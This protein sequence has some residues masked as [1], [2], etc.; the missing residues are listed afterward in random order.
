[1]HSHHKLILVLVAAGVVGYAVNR[2]SPDMTPVPSELHDV[3]ASVKGGEPPQASVPVP[4]A[5]L[6][7]SA[8]RSQS[9][10][11][12]MAAHAQFAAIKTCVSRADKVRMLELKRQQ[13]ASI[14]DAKATPAEC[15]SVPEESRAIN[16]ALSNSD[17]ATD[18]FRLQEDLTRATASAARAGDAD[19]QLC[20]IDGGYFPTE[21]S[22]IEA[23]GAEAAS[24]VNA[25]MAAGDWRVVET[26]ATP[27]DSLSHRGESLAGK[28]N[29]GSPFTAYRATRLLQYGAEGSYSQ[30]L[31][32]NAKTLRRSLTPAQV[33]NADEW[34]KDEFKRHFSESG[35]LDKA[36]ATCLAE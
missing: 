12:G 27:P 22:D 31:D 33:A 9:T 24:Y 36:P 10:G 25:R 2:H 14:S 7:Q 8:S 29:I 18:P 6:S 5:S 30:L 23:Y 3:A 1:M 26:L 15:Q 34:A 4:E 20:F 35:K 32:L 28:V 19:A 11:L 13:C 16:A 17:C 21:K